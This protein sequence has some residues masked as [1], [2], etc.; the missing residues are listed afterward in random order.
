MLVFLRFNN[1]VLDQNA[2]K[3]MCHQDKRPTSALSSG[4]HE[5]FEKFL[6]VLAY[7]HP[8]RLAFAEMCRVRVVTVS[9]DSNVWKVIWDQIQR[10]EA[11]SLVDCAA[12]FV[13]T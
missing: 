3:A 11:I 4:V 6:S 10:P 1:H 7:S 8:I 5:L 12:V 2:T 13:A 9:H